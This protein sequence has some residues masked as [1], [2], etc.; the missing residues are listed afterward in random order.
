[1]EAKV[2]K[3]DLPQHKDFGSLCHGKVTLSNQGVPP[4][5]PMICL[6]R[7]TPTRDALYRVAANPFYDD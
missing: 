2:R 6:L 4:K 1:M 5:T 3:P 7:K